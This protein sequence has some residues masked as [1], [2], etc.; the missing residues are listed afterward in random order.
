VFSLAVECTRN[1]NAAR[2]ETDP[3][4]LYINSSVYSGHVLFQH[5]GKQYKHF[6]LPVPKGEVDPEHEMVGDAWYDEPQVTQKDILLVKMRP[7][8]QL[9]MLLYAVKGVGRDHAKFSPVGKSNFE[10]DRVRVVLTGHELSHLATASY[11]LLPHIE[12]LSPIAPE[13]AAKFQACFPPGVIDLEHDEATGKKTKVVV[14]NPR[15]DTVSREVLRYPEFRDKVKLGRVRDHFICMSPRLYAGESPQ[16]DN[17]HT[18]FS[19]LSD[20]IESTGA[21]NPEELLPEAI[22]IMLDKIGSVEACMRARFP[23][24]VPAFKA[25]QFDAEEAA[26]NAGDEFDGGRA[27]PPKTRGGRKAKK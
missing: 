26:A 21:Y 20:S 24:L 3:S 19:S 9:N 18:P 8:Q 12:F 2:D 11:R 1:P 27:P 5:H 14:K 13:Y 23:S 10:T 25:P 6:N 16:A 22:S 17:S 7:G 4:K 15:L